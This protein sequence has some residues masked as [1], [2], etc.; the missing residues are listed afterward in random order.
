MDILNSL[1]GKV[2]MEAQALK[3][4]K[5]KTDKM[6][7]NFIELIF[8]RLNLKSILTVA[9]LKMSEKLLKGHVFI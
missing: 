1:L 4:K 7:R 8:S 9:S 2:G 6:G 5:Q 3:N